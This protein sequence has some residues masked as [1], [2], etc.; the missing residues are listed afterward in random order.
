MLLIGSSLPAPS[1]GFLT[2]SHICKGNFRSIRDIHTFPQIRLWR[3]WIEDVLKWKKIHKYSKFSVIRQCLLLQLLLQY[4]TLSYYRELGLFNSKSTGRESFTFSR[5]QIH[6][7]FFLTLWNF[8]KLLF[9]KELKRYERFT[10]EA[11]FFFGI[12]HMIF[13]LYPTF[14]SQHSLALIINFRSDW[15]PKWNNLM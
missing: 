13:D 1:F 4:K 14:L 7:R 9:W 6:F 5:L 15:Q 8:Q 2:Q 10:V 3:K 12:C 11:L